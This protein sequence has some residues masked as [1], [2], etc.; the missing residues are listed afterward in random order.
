MKLGIIG[1]GQMGWHMANR[2]VQDGHDVVG[3][4]PR[5]DVAGR[6]AGIGVRAVASSAEVSRVAEV[7]ILMVLNA[8]QAED[9]VWGENGFA[10]GATPTSTLA[11]MSSLPPAFLVQTVK[12]AAGRFRL[13][14]SPVSGGVEGA[15]VG[16]LTIMVAGADDAVESAMAVYRV[17][18]ETIVRL[19]TQPGLGATMKAVNQSMYICSL[20][21]AAE[22]LITATKAGLEPEAV[23]DVISQ[24]SGDSWAL[25]NRLPLTWRND[26]ISGGALALAAKDIG[27]GLELADQLGVDAHVTRAAAQVVREAMERH[28]GQ[29]DD[30]LIVETI[31][32]RSGVSLV[33]P[34]EATPGE[35]SPRSI[36]SSPDNMEG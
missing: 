7:T 12:R 17:L 13:V 4:D 23:I 5:A 21:S 2:L 9:A 19:G 27:A 24:S 31:E 34:S 10:D 1:V 36:D 16:T 20:V 26:Y 33:G 8:A 28:A 11:V 15:A 32:S 29:G 18:G 6:L 22:M 25:R 30:P 3:Y 14:D 35:H